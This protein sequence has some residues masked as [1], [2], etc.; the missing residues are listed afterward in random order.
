MIPDIRREHQPKN[1]SGV[2][3][4]RAWLEHIAAH[5]RSAVANWF[6]YAVR[7]GAASATLVLVSVR[8]G[9]AR[10]QN[11]DAQQVLGALRAD[12]AGALAYAQCVLDYERLPAQERQKVKAARAMPFVHAAMHGKPPTAPQLAYLTRLG[13]DGAPPADRAEASAL[14]D[15]LRQQKGVAR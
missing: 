13:Y 9:C 1:P 11:A 2:A 3:D 15:H 8:Q 12:P 5:R 7:S 14:I 4:P 10:R 6:H